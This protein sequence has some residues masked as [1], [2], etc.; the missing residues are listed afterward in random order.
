MDGGVS[1]NNPCQLAWAESHKTVSELRRPDQFVSVGTGACRTKTLNN[2]EVRS[3]MAFSNG[4]LYQT[5]QHYMANNFDGDKK[6]YDMRNTL[7]VAFPD[8]IDN[9][10]RWFRRFNVSLGVE[11]P[12]LADAQAM[13]GLADVAWRHF[14]SDPAIDDLARGVLA[15]SFYF[16]LRSLPI[17]DDGQYVCHGRILCR[18]PVTNAA[19]KS[20]M[21]KLDSMS[22]QFLVRQ[23]TMRGKG[24]GAFAFDKTGNFS[25]PISFRTMSLDD[26]INI[27]MKLLHVYTYDISASPLVISSLVK[28]QELDWAGLK[29]VGLKATTLAKRRVLTDSCGPKPKRR[30]V[31]I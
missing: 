28:I 1:D 8:K 25:K 4:S 2:K 3:G 22:A 27:R 26:R 12:D 24:M 31:A 13:D 10:D 11:I 18:I 7:S 20:L 14:K 15:S 5:F 9:V 29:S 21:W 23:K 16:E 30:C 19:F 17:Y 6:F